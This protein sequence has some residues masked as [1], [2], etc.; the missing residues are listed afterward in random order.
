M[1]RTEK[2]RLQRKAN[3]D[4]KAFRNVLERPQ[5]RAKYESVI[6]ASFRDGQV[7]RDCEYAV[8]LLRVLKVKGIGEKLADKIFREIEKPITEAERQLARDLYEQGGNH[9]EFGNIKA[10]SE[11]RR[12]D[13]GDE[14]HS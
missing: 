8:K 12:T 11:D 14:S 9:V 6:R 2:R 13:T 1:N 10:D 3:K 4:A 7:Y 5:D